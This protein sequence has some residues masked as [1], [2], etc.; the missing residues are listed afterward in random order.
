ME[1]QAWMNGAW[2]AE[3]DTRLPLDDAMVTHGAGL[4]EVLRAWGGVPVFLDRHLDRFMQATSEMG[5][6]LPV[7]RNQLTPLV[8]EYLRRL[9][10]ALA[11]QD[12]HVVLLATPGSPGQQT[13]TL[14]IHGRPLD[15]ARHRD[16]MKNGVALVRSKV[17]ALPAEVAPTRWKHRNRL[18][19]YLAGR[20]THALPLLETSAGII[21]ETAIGHVVM[22]EERAGR[23]VLVAPPEGLVLPGI[24]LEVVSELAGETG[25]GWERRPFHWEEL[26]GADEILMVGSGFGVAGVSRLDDVEIPWAGRVTQDM[27]ARFAAL[28]GDAR[29]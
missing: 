9:P 28:V 21:T 22:V 4:V 24:T 19:W 14:V 10:P 15:S 8:R 27:A 12:R 3:S 2:A 23:A 7:D 18:H 6:R 20:Q 11:G 25:L 5:L 16:Y 17:K 26:A 29:E 1:P 13:A